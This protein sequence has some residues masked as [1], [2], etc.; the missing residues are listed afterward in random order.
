[1]Q[2]SPVETGLEL[3][4]LARSVQ[5]ENPKMYKRLLM[6]IF[7]TFLGFSRTYTAKRLDTT[8]KTVG[9]WNQ[10]FNEE[11]KPGLL[12]KPRS[13]RPRIIDEVQR[14]LLVRVAQHD[15]AKLT[16]HLSSWSLQTLQRYLKKVY[17][18][19]ISTSSIGRILHENDIFFRKVE[20]TLVSPDP[21]YEIK[22]KILDHAR[23]EA[24]KHKD[25]VFLSLDE[26]GPIHA[27]FHRAGK[28][29]RKNTRELIPRNHNKSNGTVVLNAAFEPGSNRLWWHF[30]EKR[31]GDAFL[32]L[33]IKLS[34]DPSLQTMRKV[35][36][37]MDNLPAHFTKNIKEFLAL[38]PHFKV[39][40]LPTYSPELNPIERIFG[41]LDRQAIQN[42]YYE[43]TDQLEKRITSW[44]IDK[45]SQPVGEIVPISPKRTRKRFRRKILSWN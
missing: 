18:L 3:Y 2:I 13:G 42:H 34:L 41:D 17:E 7:V 37:V 35:Y 4:Q 8:P 15:P 22:K 28:W 20:E 9:K 30:S 31:T 25:V 10:R 39:L 24:L 14:D 16:S 19:K 40:R 1:M 43:D 33:L 5:V 29:M 21:N 12:D 36:L 27:L 11:G 32:M 23:Q 6:V 38:H 44:L 45:M 26:K